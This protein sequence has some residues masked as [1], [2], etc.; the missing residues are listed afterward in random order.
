MPNQCIIEAAPH[1]LHYEHQQLFST[2]AL[3]YLSDLV[4]QFD[5][6]V[7]QLLLNRVQRKSLISQG[8]WK[9]NF[10][11]DSAADISW[12]I[13]DLPERLQNRKLDLGDVTPANS[14]HFKDALYS[15]VHGIQVQ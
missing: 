15:D 11:N 12:R 6:R 7:K 13:A 2:E 1:R 4:V 5:S 14:V 9:L 8:K 3:Q 10:V